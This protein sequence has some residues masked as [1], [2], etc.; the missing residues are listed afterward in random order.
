MYRSYKSN[1][2]EAGEAMKGGDQKMVEPR[3]KAISG[4]GLEAGEAMKGGDLKVGETKCKPMSV[5]RLDAGEAMQG[6]DLKVGET[7]FKPVY[8]GG[9]VAGEVMQGTRLE[10]GEPRCG[11]Q[12]HL[13]NLM[14]KISRV[15]LHM[16]EVLES[17]SENVATSRE[18]KNQDVPVASIDDAEDEEYDDEEISLYGMIRPF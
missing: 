6:G 7:R 10:A 15:I 11:S 9:L 12:L 5:G 16:V 2:I 3:S 18:D 17:R 13:Q 4:E 14:E 8:G 1:L